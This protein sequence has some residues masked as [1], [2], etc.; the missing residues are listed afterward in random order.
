MQVLRFLAKKLENE[1]QLVASA[2][3]PC[4]SQLPASCIA[5]EHLPWLEKIHAYARAQLHSSQTGFLKDLAPA[6][7]MTRLK[8]QEPDDWE[9]DQVI[10]WVLTNAKR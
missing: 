7:L 1:V 9:S 5:A 10:A 8:A 6:I 4:L 2:C 3:I